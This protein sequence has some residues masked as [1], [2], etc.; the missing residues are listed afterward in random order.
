MPAVIGPMN[1]PMDMA[2]D[3]TENTV[4]SRLPPL[5]SMNMEAIAGKVIPLAI[6]RAKSDTGS[7]M[8]S[9]AAKAKK[10]RAMPKIPSSTRLYGL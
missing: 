7:G 6:P 1:E 9:S 2:M 3:C 4:P 8:K 10:D 5:R